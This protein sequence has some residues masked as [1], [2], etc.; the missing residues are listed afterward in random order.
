MNYQTILFDLDGTLLPADQ[1][2]FTS[3]Y[4]DALAERFAPL[5]YPKEKL[6]GGVWAGTRAMV[7]N[8][9]SVTNFE[10]FWKKF[11]SIFGEKVYSEIPLFDRFYETDFEKARRVCGFEM[12][13]GALVD[14]LYRDKKRLILATNPVFPRTA[15]LARL[16]WAGVDFAQFSY[17]TSYEN[18]HFGKPNVKYYLEIKEKFKIDRALM[19]GNDATEDLA[20]LGAGF[21]VFL[22]TDCLIN[23]QN[24]DLEK[25]PHGGY[26][27]LEEFLGL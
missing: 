18:S 26:S 24:V 8:D 16:R 27:E 4:F 1:E 13:A 5:G 25:I 7:E 2:E 20:A 15:Q 23:R 6:I 9:G 12:R 22:L 11:A 17:I 10:A 21:D 14:R 3:A 19:I